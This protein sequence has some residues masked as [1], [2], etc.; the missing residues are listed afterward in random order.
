MDGYQ[1]ALQTQTFTP[2]TPHTPHTLIRLH[3]GLHVVMDTFFGFIYFS[4]R[5]NFSF[6]ANDQCSPQSAVTI[7]YLV[8]R[9]SV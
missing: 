4:F 7:Q 3:V 5:S 9:Y 8:A 2:F 1:N 6:R